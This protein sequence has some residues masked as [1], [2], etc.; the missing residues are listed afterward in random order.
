M[1]GRGAEATERTES[2]ACRVQGRFPCEGFAGIGDLSNRS[3]GA[4]DFLGVEEASIRSGG[5]SQHLLSPQWRRSAPSGAVTQQ[6]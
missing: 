3:C 4:E 5:T 6:Y 2:N 1:L